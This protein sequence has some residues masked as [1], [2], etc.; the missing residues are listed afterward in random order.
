MGGLWR[1]GWFEAEEP[2][3]CSVRVAGNDINVPLPPEVF[4]LLPIRVWQY[5]AV[6]T[7]MASLVVGQVCC[8]YAFFASRDL[9]SRLVFASL[10]HHTH[11]ELEGV[12][13]RKPKAKVESRGA[14]KKTMIVLGSGGH[15]AEMLRV[16]KHM[17]LAKYRPRC[18]VVSGTDDMSADRALRFEKE[19]QEGGLDPGQADPGVFDIPRSREVGQS[20][21]TSV[22]TTI[23]S[24]VASA[25]VVF[26]ERP[27][28]LLCNGEPSAHLPPLPSPS[29]VLSD[30]HRLPPPGP[31]RTQRPR[32]LPA[33]LR[34][35]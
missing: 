25:A 10:D 12:R 29:T 14:A 6:I 32:H 20:Y 5:L 21:V 16:L 35:P 26:V 31:S 17:D 24:L 34:G 7:L 27:A 33:G 15:T 19:R 8:F 11:Q 22:F 2:P 1:G 18:Y 3:C 30:F 4:N 28:L 9:I 13:I 23:R